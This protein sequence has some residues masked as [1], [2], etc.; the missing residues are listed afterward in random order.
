M[1]DHV[2]YNISE[3]T[4]EILYT[5]VWDS[6]Q[7]NHIDKIEK[8]QQRSARYDTGR[9]WN[10]SSVNNMMIEKW[11]FLVNTVTAWN[12]LP[13]ILPHQSILRHSSLKW[14]NPQTKSTEH[15]FNPFSLMCNLPEYLSCWIWDIFRRRRV[16]ICNHTTILI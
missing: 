6:Y 16:P 14:L 5:T 10:R 2:L 4:N 8:V 12:K 15:F 3:T 1:K 11:S 9:H 7:Q 13:Q